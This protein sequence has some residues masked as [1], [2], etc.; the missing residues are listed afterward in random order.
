M[1]ADRGQAETRAMKSLSAHIRLHAVRELLA[2]HLFESSDSR[3]EGALN[4]HQGAAR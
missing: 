1:G 3:I 2:E 4:L